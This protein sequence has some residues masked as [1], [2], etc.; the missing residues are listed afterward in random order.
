MPEEPAG[1]QPADEPPAPPE[2]G[3]TRERRRGGLGQPITG[4]P[5]AEPRPD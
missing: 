5:A 2:G 1:A 3:D 4:A